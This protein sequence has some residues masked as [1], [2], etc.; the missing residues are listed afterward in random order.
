MKSIKV[1]GVIIEKLS[2]PEGASGVVRRHAG[3]TARREQAIGSDSKAKTLRVGRIGS[4]QAAR[5][6]KGRTLGNSG[7]D[8]HFVGF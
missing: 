2:A 3:R 4:L 7:A 8:F 5:E 6:N 1:A